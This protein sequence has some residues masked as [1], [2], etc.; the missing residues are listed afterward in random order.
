MKLTGGSTAVGR[1]D[2]RSHLIEETHSI[3][4]S[5]KELLMWVNPTNCIKNKKSDSSG[6]ITN[7]LMQYTQILIIVLVLDS[8]C[9]QDT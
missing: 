6:I 4:V 8:Y 2:L 5:Y 7:S 3:Q 9:T 1:E